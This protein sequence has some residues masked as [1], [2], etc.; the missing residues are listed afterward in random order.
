MTDETMETLPLFDQDYTL[1]D[2]TPPHENVS[3]SLAAGESMLPTVAT[4]Q[5]KV[6]DAI[7]WS[8]DRGLTDDEIEEMLELRHQTASARR[9]ELFLKGLI[10][11]DGE[12]RATSSGRQ[13][14]VWVIAR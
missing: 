6:Y 13:A 8:G 10:V 12:T 14:K 1:Y 5:R 7:R 3:T 9:R 11:N 4:L 2:G